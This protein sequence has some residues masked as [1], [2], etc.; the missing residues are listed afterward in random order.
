MKHIL[1]L[2][3]MATALICSSC[4]NASRS[5]ITAW[6]LKHK[7]ELYSGG[8]LI[9]TWFTTGRIE[10][11]AGNGHYFQDDKTGN[12]VQITDDIIVTIEK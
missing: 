7:V 11:E 9:G 3:M 4:S 10:T 1:F 8:K 5:A 2:L 12:I 6:G